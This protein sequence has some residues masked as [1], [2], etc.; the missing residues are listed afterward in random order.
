RRVLIRSRRRRRVAGL[1]VDPDPVLPRPRGRG[2]RD[3]PRHPP[4][5]GAAVPV[6][7][8]LAHRPA[9]GRAA[10]LRARPPRGDDHR[11]LPG[12][13]RGPRH[14]AARRGPGRRPGTHADHHAVA[15]TVAQHLAQPGTDGGGRLMAIVSQ[16]PGR[17]G[18]G[19]ELVLLLLGLA[20]GLY[21]YL[22]V[23][24]AT[25]GA[26]PA[27]IVTQVGVLVVLALVTHVV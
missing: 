20:I 26:P 3:L 13:G 11:L 12:P 14:R 21:A 9:P 10:R 17:R 22:Q 24:L 1:P 18:R 5:A 27:D 8:P 25:E 19:V 16:Q 6:H 2:R 4:G 23:G 7:R 15:R